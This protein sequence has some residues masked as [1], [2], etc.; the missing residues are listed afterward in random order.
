MVQILDSI[1]AILKSRC[2]GLDESKK[3]M[4]SPD[5]SSDP[6]LKV[7]KMRQSL[8]R[9]LNCRGIISHG[10]RSKHH[11]CFFGFLWTT[12]EISPK[13]NFASVSWEF[14]SGDVTE[15]SRSWQKCC[16][17][18]FWDAVVACSTYT[19]YLHRSPNTELWMVFSIMT[20]LVLITLFVITISANAFLL[21]L[22]VI[23]SLTQ[24]CLGSFND[25][26]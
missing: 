17:Q 1:G 18:P 7:E 9:L 19:K 26:H 2:K 3:N 6:S 22:M 13:T 10:Q 12:A 5:T 24:W 21:W 4:I 20:L 11:L 23:T 15:C 16:Q 8:C 25:V 14:S